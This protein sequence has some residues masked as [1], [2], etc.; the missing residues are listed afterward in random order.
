MDAIGE[1]SDSLTHLTDEDS[2]A[3]ED[4][5][6]SRSKHHHQ[7]PPGAPPSLQ[8]AAPHASVNFRSGGDSI[9]GGSGAGLQLS[10]IAKPH[11]RSDGPLPP[12]VPSDAVLRRHRRGSSS[13]T[14][15]RRR[16]L[17]GSSRVRSCD[18]EHGASPL[19]LRHLPGPSSI[20]DGLF[21]R[22]PATVDIAAAAK[23]SL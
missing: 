6:K 16:L 10:T 4:R 21:P 14:L 19:L 13:S 8:V 15:R 7:P 18:D 11:R 22:R 3:Y 2:D 9:V 20:R 12:V 23:V 5:R 1:D 17:P